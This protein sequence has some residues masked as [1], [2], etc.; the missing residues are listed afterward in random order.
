MRTRFHRS[1]LS[2]A[3]VLL[4]YAISGHA[5]E[6][7]TPN[8]VADERSGAY[9]LTGATVTISP[10]KVLSDAV[11]LIREG[12]IVA[13]EAGDRPVP[14]GYATIDL[15]G[16]YIYP[17]L[18]DIDGTYG[19]PEPAKRA[20]FSFS[21]PE[22]LE[23]QT[24]GAYNPNQAI[25]AEYDAVSEFT[26]K[27][28]DAATWRGMGFGAVLTS[29]TDGIARGSGAL[30]TLGEVSDNEAVLVPRAAAVYSFDKGSSSQSFPISPM[31]AVALLRQTYLDATWYA[32]QSPKPFTDESLGAW[33][34]LQAL[35][36]IFVVDD[37]MGALR[38]DLVGDEFSVQ[39]VIREGGD[40][41]QRVDA[42]KAMGAALIV[43]LEFPEAQDVTDPF[44][45]DRISYTDLKHWELAPSN[46]ARLERAGVTFALTSSGDAKQFW[47]RLRKAIE[48]GLSEERALAA[49][50][51]VPAALLGE[52][53]RLGEL[54]SGAIG[55]LIVTSAPLFDEAMVIEEN[56][57]AGKRYRVKGHTPDRRGVYALSVGSRAYELHVSGKP[58]APKAELRLPVEEEIAADTDAAEPTPIAAVLAFD[59]DAITM[60]FSPEEDGAA[61]R[62]GGWELDDHWAGEGRLADGAPVKWRAV[63]AANPSAEGEDGAGAEEAGG[64]LALGK[65]IYPFTAYGTGKP[66]QP[67]ALLIRNATVWTLEGEG[68]L[69][70]ADVLVRDGRIS[71]VGK[72]LADRDARVI[73]ATGMHVTPGII[74]E[75][76]HIAL[77]GVNDIATNS[78][79]VRMGD[80]VNS[81]DVNIYRNLAGGVTAAQLLHGSA[82]PVGG[83]SALV[84]MRWGM[85]PR[86]MLIDGADGF[87]KFALGENVKR[88]RN[89]A[90]IR[91]PQTRMGVEQVFRDG[92][93]AAREYQAA[94][95][96]WQALGRA[97]KMRIR[98]PRRDLVMDAMAE[99]LN[100]ERF[101]SCHSYVQSEINMLMHVADDFDFTVNTFTH[102]LE[103]YKVADKMAAHG[104]A[105][106]TFSD[107]WA[108]KWEV[109]YAIPYNAALMTEAGVLSAINSD[110]AEMSRRL[111]QEAAKSVKYGGMSEVEALKL[112][113]LNPAKM[114][115][116]ADR[117]G[118]IRTGKDADLVIWTDNPLSIDAK[119]LHTI[120]DGVVRYDAVEHAARHA[121]MEIERARLIE[122]M[123]KAKGAKGG[124]SGY[125]PQRL[126]HCDSLHGYEYLSNHGAHH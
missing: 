19:L 74:D 47:P 40:A 1:P 46:A 8:D 22:V 12:Q 124:G 15:S 21:K 112:V 56:W 86:E 76:S 119:A 7:A 39:Y 109:R 43:P 98:A 68:K 95:A 99:I 41:Y 57:V 118:S 97:E 61:I 66:P 16:R 37:W 78:S 60:S 113:T 101:I 84:K 30:V 92:F 34:E 105:G 64:Q 106:S 72:G 26:V 75:H 108:Y 77:S 89:P 63:R 13:V 69:D 5:Q 3:L 94:W 25:R 42:I 111:N 9:A 121:A 51:T 52:S 44:A 53:M 71:A 36:Q 6:T 125:R 93:G 96:A 11:V 20:P 24:P 48:Y 54:R 123:R 85:L 87:I 55:N 17:G 2:G 14:A 18:I 35:P 81:E 27:A 45:A 67:E 4:A 65:V 73:D 82:N 29:M 83:Q 90:S 31:G 122:K 120:V 50:T 32:G 91:Y 110:S 100:N 59:G 79:M 102:I 126:W 117:M 38:A 70:A 103:G 33:L 104:A 107:W 58:T 10:G 23:S 28:K 88:S 62:L 80:V 115:H 114:L 116:L 49:L